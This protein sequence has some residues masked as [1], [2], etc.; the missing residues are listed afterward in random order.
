MKWLGGDES[1]NVEYSSGGG[2][3]RLIGGGIGAGIIGLI[4][5]L[6]TGYTPQQV[7]RMAAPLQQQREE[8]SYDHAPKGSIGNFASIVLRQTEIVWDSL[9]RTNGMT[10]QKPKMRIFEGETYSGC[11]GASAAMGPFYC[12]SDNKIYLD[13][14]FFNE[15][16]DRFGAPGD[17]ANAYVIAH[18]VG[19]H[20]QY[21]LGT[22]ERM[23]RLRDDGGT[24][25]HSV[26]VMIEL[27]A[28]FYAGVWA[29]Y[30]EQMNGAGSPVQIE[31]GDIEAALR[32]ASAVGDDHL[33]QMT[34][35]RVMP[36]AFTHGTSKQRMY[37]FKKGYETGD[38]QQG[39]TFEELRQ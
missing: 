7:N 32:A 10:Y 36:D 16:K 38:M 19:H 15:L 34:Q 37:W 8:V 5:Y 31:P 4:I 17:F 1:N 35:G 25:P 22:T 13:V 14:S 2:S 28:D 11:G 12:P 24:G 6:V 3:G 27:Q 26:S 21:L 23:G 33:Q 18:E 29:H 20:I 9:F 39:N 30:A